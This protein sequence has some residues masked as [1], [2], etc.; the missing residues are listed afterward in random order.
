MP[1][2]RH[3]LTFSHPLNTPFW[4]VTPMNLIMYC[5]CFTF[6]CCAKKA[7]PNGVQ[8]SGRSHGFCNDVKM[9]FCNTLC[10][11]ELCECMLSKWGMPTKYHPS[12]SH[13]ALV[14][15]HLRYHQ[16]DG[17]GDAP[18]VSARGVPLA[19]SAGARSAMASKEGAGANW[20]PWICIVL[21]R[22]F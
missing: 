7:N 6:S 8:S 5:R 16:I 14:E 9:L 4:L 20:M 21:F 15:Y 10:C 13:L 3:M 18:Q 11:K 17:D 19:A 12:I 2:G 22:E 1:E